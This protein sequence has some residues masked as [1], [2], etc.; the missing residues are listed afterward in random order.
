MSAVV[1][2]K[3]R[4]SE[5]PFNKFVLNCKRRK[6]SEDASTTETAT[7]NLLDSIDETKTIL[8]FAATIKSADDV[9]THINRLRKPDAEEVV[10]KIRMP[11]NV[12]SKNRQQLKTDLQSNRFKVVNCYRSI[13]GGATENSANLT[14]VD[15]VKEDEKSNTSNADGDLT[16]AVDM[17]AEAT[18]SKPIVDE[19]FVYDLYLIDGTDQNTEIDIENLIS[20]RP[21]D[22]LVYQHNDERFNDSDMDSEDSN[23]EDNWRNEYPD[24]DDDFSIGEEDM[25]RAVEDLQMGSDENL[26]SDE[27][28]YAK[29]PIVHFLDADGDDNELN[30]FDY[31]KKHGR[32][33]AHKQYYRNQ[34]GSR[35]A[36]YRAEIET[37][38]SDSVASEVP[39]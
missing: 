4:I 25:R 19:N 2:V 29:E 5:E 36:K 35:R 16:N 14:I 15:V 27:S 39:D 31:F 13:N 21:F 6:T 32:M 9:I 1:R 38:D 28:D 3:R 10:R 17:L 23:D 30:E 37:S 33:Q 24:T 20:I 8:K 7:V 12:T 22:D 11:T 26:S 18:A 34:D